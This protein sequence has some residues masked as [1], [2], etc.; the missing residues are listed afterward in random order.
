MVKRVMWREKAPT[1][2][3]IL[4]SVKKANSMN[5]YNMYNDIFC[6]SPECDARKRETSFMVPLC[7]F[8]CQSVLNYQ[9]VL[10]HFPFC[11]LYSTMVVHT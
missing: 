4:Q 7:I 9:Q 8:G 11:L 5:T 1:C 2:K 3:I 6:F 10:K